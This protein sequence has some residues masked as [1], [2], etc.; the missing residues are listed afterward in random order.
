MLWLVR[1][2]RLKRDHGVA[3]W[4][5]RAFGNGT[6]QR[7]ECRAIANAFATPK[8][9]ERKDLGVRPE[10]LSRGIS[11]A[12]IEHDDLVLARVILEHRPDAPE[13]YTDSLCFVVGGYADVQHRAS[14]RVTGQGGRFA[15]ARDTGTREPPE[16]F[17]PVQIRGSTPNSRNANRFGRCIGGETNRPSGA[18]VV[19]VEFWSRSRFGHGPCL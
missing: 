2:V 12:V 1:E 3:P 10:R 9:G 6:T 8:N 11:A 15:K 4:I 14:S 7:I 17:T 18:S 5:A 16:D 19:E 13:Q